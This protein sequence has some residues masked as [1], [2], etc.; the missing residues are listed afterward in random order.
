M[1]ERARSMT[2]ASPEGIHEATDYRVTV[3]A[4][5]QSRRSSGPAHC[6]RSGS[7]HLI[8]PRPVS[9]TCQSRPYTNRA[10]HG[11]SNIGPGSPGV[12]ATIAV[13]PQGSG[14]IYVGSVGGGVRKSTDNGATW[15][16]VS[17]GLHA[18]AVF[19]LATDASGPDTVYAGVFS[20]AA[21][22]PGGVYRSVDGG[23]TWTFLAQTAMTIPQSLAAH[24]NASGV[25]YMADLG[26]R[27]FKT[28]D[29]GANWIR[30]FTGPA[31]VTSIIIDPINPNTVYATTLAGFLK[32][33][34]AGA[35]WSLMP[36]LSSKPLWD[37][38]ID[39]TNHDVLYV[40]TNTS[41]V[42]RSPD[43]GDSWQPTGPLS[44]VPYSVS[45]DP[46]PAHAIFVGTSEGVLEEFGRRRL[47]AADCAHRQGGPDDHHRSRGDSVRGNDRGSGYL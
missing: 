39:P 14:T 19:A 33:I 18:T 42:W 17:S 11:W 36:G 15:S 9:G 3:F 40:A 44:A 10:S 43:A 32:S 20:V 21:T 12:R 38:A 37:V 7:Q 34:N 28:I 16:S 25:V 27:I 6:E 35:T 24:P 30:V 31:V 1:I 26:Q 29:G 45:V 41:G 2:A 23:S 13:D 8:S 5:A 4:P 22:A 47:V 46:S